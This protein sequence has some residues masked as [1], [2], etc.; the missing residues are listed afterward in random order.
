MS[1]HKGML[2]CIFC[3]RRFDS[4]SSS[5]SSIGEGSIPAAALQDWHCSL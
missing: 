2:N 5:S 3:R 1:V 4:S